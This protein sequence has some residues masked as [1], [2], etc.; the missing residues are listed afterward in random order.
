MSRRKD[1]LLRFKEVLEGTEGIAGVC[2]RM[3]NYSE[4]NGFPWL[5]IFSGG[6]A[7]SVGFESPESWED[8]MSVIVRGW[9]KETADQIGEDIVFVDAVCQMED[10]IETIRAA[11]IDDYLS[12][13]S[14]ALGTMDI[15]MTPGEVRETDSGILSEIGMAYFE[16]QFPVRIMNYH[17]D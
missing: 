10:V 5:M 17:Y 12:S 14:G 7:E 3:M 11:I 15:I 8:R 4:C 16:L 6:A 13:A 9:V 2:F 1:I